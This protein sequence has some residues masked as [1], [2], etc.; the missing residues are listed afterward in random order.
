MKRSI[1]IHWV[2][3]V[4]GSFCLSAQLICHAQSAPTNLWVLDLKNYHADSSPG[5]A[6]DGTI[7][8]AN[9]AGKLLAITPQGKVKWTFHAGREIKSSPAIADDG[10][11]YF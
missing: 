6:A 3:I 5:I 11:I 4:A 2:K 8:Q 7:Y 9:F 1:I 10:T